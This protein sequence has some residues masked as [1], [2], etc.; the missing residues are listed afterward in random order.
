M[1]DDETVMTMGISNFF[2]KEIVKNNPLP[3][4]ARRFSHRTYELWF[5]MHCYSPACYI[6]LCSLILLPSEEA[7]I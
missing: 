2:F 5:I 4:Q 6:A 7:S 1:E 3:K